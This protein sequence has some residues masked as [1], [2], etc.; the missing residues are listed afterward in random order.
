M[1]LGNERFLRFRENEKPL[2][3]LL[4]SPHFGNF[5]W[6]DFVP[7]FRFLV[8]FSR[9]VLLSDVSYEA[10]SKCA[11]KSR[12]WRVQRWSNL[13]TRLLGTDLVTFEVAGAPEFPQ[14]L[15]K[16]AATSPL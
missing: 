5:L 13:E 11:G 16:F 4:N 9:I 3:S 8:S 6:T 1:K 15:S 7:K 14:L 10:N 12:A 2:F